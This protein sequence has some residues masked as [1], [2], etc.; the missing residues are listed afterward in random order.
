MATLTTLSGKVS[1]V[2]PIQASGSRQSGPGPDEAVTA[3]SF[4]VGSQPAWFS[5]SPNLGEGDVVTVAGVTRAGVLA[6][7]AIRN[8]STGV[9][10]GGATALQY[11][12]LG[13]ALLFGIFTV[14]LGGLG[15]LFLALAGWVWT[16]VRRRT[17]ALALV[18]AFASPGRP[19]GS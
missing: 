8:R 4:R 1:Q 18:R 11:F 3:L 6:A 13:L 15:V 10:Y 5:G 16:G 12:L 2:A 19:S 17:R 7:L 9:D 14:R